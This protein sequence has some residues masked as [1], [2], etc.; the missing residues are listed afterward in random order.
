[1][2]RILIITG[3]STDVGKTV[4]TAAV[5]ALHPGCTIVKPAQTGL[6]PHE[7]GD[8]AVAA[9]LAGGRE[10]RE[11]VR[12]PEPLA[13]ATAARRANVPAMTV[14]EMAERIAATPGD[15][16]IVEGAGGLLVR[17]DSEHAGLVELA[18]VLE[19]RGLTP[20]FVLV[21][22]PALG[23]LN[24]TALTLRELERHGLRAASLVIGTWPDEP[25]LAHRCNVADLAELAREHHGRAQLAGVL[26]AGAGGLHPAEFA[27]VAKRSL[28]PELG[29]E[30]DY[31]A[32]AATCS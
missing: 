4:A 32:F 14:A 1:M 2:T 7:D 5:A 20:E 13:P 6:A 23:A 31:R 24:Q 18:G 15:P 17:F 26:P 10:H 28:G 25:D 11:F 16:V 9:R 12:Y 30:F 8:A 3:T 19:A 29:G 21:I 22:H 27:V